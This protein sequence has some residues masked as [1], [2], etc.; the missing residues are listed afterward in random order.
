MAS[1]IEDGGQN[2]HGNLPPATPAYVFRGHT[3]AVNALHFFSNNAYLASADADGWIV[4]WSLVTRRPNAVWRAHQGGILGI[5]NWGETTLITYVTGLKN[6][7]QGRA[8]CF[9]VM[10]EIM[11]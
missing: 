1:Q 2:S 11:P 3:S 9:L 7:Q 5:K 6:G 10:E 8:D 4:V